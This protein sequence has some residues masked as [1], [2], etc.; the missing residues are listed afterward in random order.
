MSVKTVSEGSWNWN[1]ATK[2]ENKKPEQTLQINKKFGDILE[3]IKC[4]LVN[5]AF[6]SDLCNLHAF[7]NQDKYVDQFL[8]I[9]NEDFSL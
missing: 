6:V 4:Q 7:E 3:T 1:A 8:L 9:K 2:S 5:L